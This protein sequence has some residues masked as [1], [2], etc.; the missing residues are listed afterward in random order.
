MGLPSG[1]EAKHVAG[2]L[3]VAELLRKCKRALLGS[4][5]VHP[6]P[7]AQAPFWRNG[8]TAGKYVVSPN[9]VQHLRPSE[10]I[11]IDTVGAWH[12]D[13]NRAHVGVLNVMRVIRI[14]ICAIDGID[15]VHRFW[16]RVTKIERRVTRRIDQHAD[17]FGRNVE[18]DRRVRVARIQFGIGIHA[19]HFL[20]AALVE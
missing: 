4:T 15:R 7:K 17:T 9:R 8:A 13:G 19:R 11:D 20:L 12:F 5:G 16:P 1:L 6:V 2:Y 10:E 18:R 14:R 3:V